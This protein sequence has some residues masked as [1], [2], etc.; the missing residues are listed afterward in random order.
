MIFNIKVHSTLFLLFSLLLIFF[1]HFKADA[2]PNL[3]EELDLDPEIIENSP[4]LQKWNEEIP[5]VAEEIRHD[6]SFKTRVQLGFVQYPSSDDIG[7]FKVGIEDMFLGETGITAN[8]GYSQ[9]FNRDRAH[10]ESDLA[11]SL[12]PLGN[13]FNVAPVVG[14]HSIETEDFSEDGV[15]VGLQ[16]RLTLSRTGAADLRLTQSFISPGEDGEVGLTTIAAGYAV[17]ERLRLAVEIQKQNSSFENDSRVGI[18]SE[19]QFP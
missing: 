17:T 14:Y 19:W 5:N 7:G 10:W 1:P 13:Q 8:L 15:N 12:L 2:N 4:V 11:Y 3:G 18:L 16:L 6:P 9:S